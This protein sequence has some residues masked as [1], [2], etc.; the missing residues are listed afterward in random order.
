M[1]V[2]V[3]VSGGTDSLVTL[4]LL[5]QEGFD[6]M[7]LHALFL[8]KRDQGSDDTCHQ[9]KKYC[10]QL[11]VP[12]Y[13]VDIS[14]SFH[15]SVVEPFVRSYAKGLT[16][17]PCALCNKRI[18]FDVLLTKAVELGADSLA[19]GH[20]A[21]LDR[22]RSGNKRLWRGSD[23]QKDQSYFLSLVT[24]DSLS[25]AMF[26]LGP[27]LKAAVQG[28]FLDVFGSFCP[29]Q[30]SQEICF[31]PENDYRS[32][33]EG[34]GIELPG[35]GPIEDSQG[36]RLGQHLGIHRY[37]IGQ[38][39]GL[40]IPYDHPLYVLE[41]RVRENKLIVGN[42]EELKSGHCRVSK[43]NFIEDWP[44]WPRTVFVQTVY[45]HQAKRA[46][47]KKDDRLFEVSYDQ[48][49]KRAT[50][51]QVAAFYSKDGQVLGGGLIES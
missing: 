5:K 1:T 16:P 42:Q 25:R 40:G 8:P 47:V 9:L 37:T 6:L 24:K 32:F 51:G 50:P 11:D 41:K 26:P 49:R 29:K 21:R 4:Y 3:A 33:L 13:I 10:Q 39:R 44:D 20:Y 2:A 31:V 46:V 28:L 34:F 22:D 30:E 17:N 14:D 43:M 36:K 23:R 38:R 19:T 18:K 35:P 15:S 7:A 48:P 45:R 27:R 12:L